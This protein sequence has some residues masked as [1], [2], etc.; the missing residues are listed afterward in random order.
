MQRLDIDSLIYLHPSDVAKVFL[1]RQYPKGAGGC[2]RIENEVKPAD[3]YIYLSVKYGRPNGLQNF[4]RK[5]DS[6]NLIHWDWSFGHQNG[7]VMIMGL[8]MRT[9]VHFIGDWSFSDAGKVDFINDVKLNFGKY[10]KE[11]SDFRKASL[12]DWEVFVNPYRMISDSIN[13]LNAELRELKLD[14]KGDVIPNPSSLEGY[15]EFAKAFEAIGKKYDKGVGLSMAIRMM[16]PVLAESYI[17]LLI[18]LLVRSDIRNNSRLYE[19]FIR[20]NI[21]V[22]VQSL[23]INCVGFKS[24]VDWATEPCKKYN[25]IIN[26]RNDDLHGN[27]VPEKTKF[28]EIYFNG[29]VPV[30][31]N[32]ST[33]W[34]QSLGVSINSS[35]IGEIGV[36]I[37]EIEGFM[38]YIKSCLDDETRAVVEIFE[39]K[40]DIGRRKENGRLGILLPDYVVDFG[41][42]SVRKSA[43]AGSTEEMPISDNS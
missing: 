13:A 28:M 10:G 7:M 29:K 36:W 39:K 8:N 11:M 17:N 15:E 27:I 23:S 41:V 37:K 9:E 19:S 33:M 38:E 22:K 1:E 32:Y 40:R 43:Q 25:S 20:S 3:L 2:W 31:K 4:V 26:N 35:G 21:D 18:L 12:E 5:D 30:F 42:S 14:P 34:Q 24:I 16:L 6:D